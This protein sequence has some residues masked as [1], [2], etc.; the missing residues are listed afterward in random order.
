[1]PLPKAAA[2]SSM[3][4]QEMCMSWHIPSRVCDVWIEWDRRGELT[5]IVLRGS[6]ANYYTHDPFWMQIW[7]KLPKPPDEIRKHGG[8]A[9]MGAMNALGVTTI[10]ER[11][12]MDPVHIHAY[13]KL[14][15]DQAMSCR[16][17]TSLESAA[18][19]FT[20]IIGPPRKSCSGAGTGAFP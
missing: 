14:Q 18:R 11:H 5:G 15:R 8:R 20:H 17:Q 7:D 12:A 10:Y 2:M 19:V 3:A 13:Q 1:M 9:G 4:L 16:V 6:A